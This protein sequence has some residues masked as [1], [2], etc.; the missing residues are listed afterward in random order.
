MNRS[1]RS[2]VASSFTILKGAM[3]DE[4]Y[5]VLA[6]WDF[7]LSKRENLDRLR[8]DNF[9]GAPTSTWLRD[10]AWVMNR[11]F[12]PSARDRALTI[13][14]KSGCPIDEWKPLLLWHITRD[15]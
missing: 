14:A 9:I 2:H 1:V 10:V 4:T 8:R 12:E 11:R 3:I 6:A 13:L 15:E 5:A 7:T